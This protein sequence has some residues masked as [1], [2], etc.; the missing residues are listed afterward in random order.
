MKKTNMKQSR[1]IN[2]SNKSC[3]IP[4]TLV[5]TF[6]LFWVFSNE[7]R[8]WCLHNSIVPPLTLM[9]VQIAKALLVVLLNKVVFNN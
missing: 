4:A 8:H 7:T 5:D 6:W 3:V 1:L 9:E 2:V